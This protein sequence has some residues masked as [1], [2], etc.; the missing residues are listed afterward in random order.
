EGFAYRMPD[1][2]IR[3]W[4][5]LCPHRAQAL[6]LGDG[7][8]FNSLGEI[9]CHAHG[10]RFDASSGDCTSGPCPGAVLQRVPIRE[11]SGTVWLE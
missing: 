9:E 8:L 1:G 6:D 7:R 11:E 2:T 10:A 3:A 5:N 4:V